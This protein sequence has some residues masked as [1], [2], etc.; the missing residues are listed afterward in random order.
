MRSWAESPFTTMAHG[1]DSISLILNATLAP[2]DALAVQRFRTLIERVDVAR[3]ALMHAH[4]GVYADADQELI[5]APRLSAAACSG[6]TVLPVESVIEG[7]GWSER[8]STRVLVGQSLLI[9]PPR[10]PFWLALLRFLVDRYDPN[11]CIA[12]HSNL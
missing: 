2:A 8:L 4:G 7:H 5:S 11:C 10:T 6:L 1:D 3:Y 12:K 9:S